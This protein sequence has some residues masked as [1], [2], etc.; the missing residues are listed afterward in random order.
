MNTQDNFDGVINI[1]SGLTRGTKKPLK[2]RG[3]KKRLLWVTVLTAAL[4]ALLCACANTKTAETLE[5]HPLPQEEQKDG[6]YHISTALPDLELEL[7]I[8]LDG[9]EPYEP[10]ASMEPDTVS[11]DTMGETLCD[12]MIPD[13]TRIVCYQEMDHQVYPDP[14]YKKYWAIRQKDSLLRFCKEE[15]GYTYDYTVSSFENILGH[16]GFR[17]ECPRGASYNARDYYYIDENGV[18]R[19]LAECANNVMKMD[20]DGDGDNELLCEYHYPG[21]TEITVY[22]R[23]DGIVYQVD[24]CDLIRSVWPEAGNIEV[25]YSNQLA[26]EVPIPG[27]KVT[28]TAFRTLLFDGEN[29]R[30]YK[31][32]TPYEDH[33][34]VGLWLKAA[35]ADVLAAAQDFV[36]GEL[37]AMI[38]RATDDLGS[39][40][41]DDWRITKLIGPYYETVEDLQ[42]EIWLLGYEIHT[43]TPE[44]MVLAGG[45]YRGE[46]GWCMDG[47]P[48]SDI[49][50]FRVDGDDDRTFLYAR[51][52]DCEP[53]T[54]VFREDLIHDLKAEGFLPQT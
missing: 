3:Q 33:V 16:D 50:Y 45:S 37:S 39:V 27:S 12:W 44:R 38:E 40:L 46:D 19:L 7:V 28:A 49:L 8:P 43:T 30:L 35:P 9:L 18:P 47:Y 53:G 17:I 34:K 2:K 54:I 52:E 4:S 21:G 6:G 22:L 13:G 15:S 10:L 24:I 29:L 1:R 14:E 42:V 48:D 36:Q 25:L 11:V 51:M 5:D 20:L 32:E 26:I 23:R 31:D 41:W